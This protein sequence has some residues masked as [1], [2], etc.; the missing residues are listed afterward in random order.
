MEDDEWEGRVMR[1]VRSPWRER[2]IF[3]RNKPVC[4]KRRGGGSG[5]GAGERAGEEK[6]GLSSK[7]TEKPMTTAENLALM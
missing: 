1:R 5:A 7:R 4:L 3:G 6:E 2:R